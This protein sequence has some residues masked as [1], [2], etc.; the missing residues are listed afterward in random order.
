MKAAA[1]GS[2]DRLSTAYLIAFCC[3]FASYMRMPTVPLLAA[4]LGADPVQV[5]LINGAFMLIAALLSIPSGRISDRF[6]RRLPLLGGLLVLAATSTLLFW[7]ATLWQMAACYLCF[8]LGLSTFSPAL[9]AHVGDV[10]RAESRGEAFGRY[11]MAMY[12]GMTLGPAA[13][14]IL[15]KALGLR[16]V[17]PLAGGLLFAMFLV[18]LLF[19]PMPARGPRQGASTPALLP[20]LRDLMTNRQL[21][22]C[23]AA[24]LGCCVGYGMFVTFMPLYLVDLGM[25]ALQVGLVFAAAALANT[26]SRLPAGKQCDRVLDRALLVTW[27]LALFALALALFALCRS[28]GSFICAAALMGL[29][30]G[31]AFTVIC[32]MIADAVPRDTRGLAVGCYNTCIYAGML[33]GS[34]GMGPLVRAFGFRTGFFLNGALGLLVLLLFKQLQRRCLAVA[35]G[36]GSTV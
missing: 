8:G 36:I 4:D 31:L 25:D 23:L 14:G 24:D 5:G 11:T 32:A 34:V 20:A 15:A 27:G 28:A 21:I 6:G 22:A 9:M 35:D 18:A 13:G 30:M 33:L 26:L 2:G 17:F 3:F 29:G 12:A 16:T 19:H 1:A 10:T 7:C